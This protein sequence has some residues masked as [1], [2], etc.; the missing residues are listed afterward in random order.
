M[1]R[2]LI[3]NIV[4][5]LSQWK[6]IKIFYQHKKIPSNYRNK[7]KLILSKV[8]K[9]NFLLFSG[10]RYLKIPKMKYDFIFVDGPNYKDQDGMSCSFDIIYILKIL[11][12]PLNAL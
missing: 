9:D 3:K 10:Y 8:I 4:L 2:I 11:L 5:V 6:I 7:V 1:L 12:T